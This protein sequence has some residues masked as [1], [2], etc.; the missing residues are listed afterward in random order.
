[1]GIEKLNKNI[2]TETIWGNS[3]LDLSLLKKRGSAKTPSGLMLSYMQKA[4]KDSNFELV[5]LF[6]ELYH[7]LRRMESSEN[8]RA[9]QWRG[10]SG[11]NFITYPDKVIA[12]RYRK[13]DI[14][15]KPVEVRM[16]ISKEEINRVINA[17]R[18]LN[19]GKEI[20]T[21]DI[22]E[23]VYNEPWKRVFSNRPEHIKLCEILNYLEYR[24]TI[25]YLRCGKVI[26][27]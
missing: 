3:R 4:K 14:G 20:E 18:K 26:V 12:I 5:Q 1:M 6:Q 8:F 7:Q 23:L 24:K 21:R 27:K 19:T 9:T 17:I 11:V 25:E 16:E 10:R 2:E 15:S 13:K 22:A